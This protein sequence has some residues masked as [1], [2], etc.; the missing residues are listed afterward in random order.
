MCR[1]IE[2]FGECSYPNCTF[3][4]TR[5]ELRK[6]PKSQLKYLNSETGGMVPTYEAE[7]QF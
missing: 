7:I 1:N 2:Q 3:A 6:V 4:H 5:N